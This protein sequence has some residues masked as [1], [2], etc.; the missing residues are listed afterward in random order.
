MSKLSKAVLLMLVGV[1]IVV[2]VGWVNARGAVSN[3][4][5]CGAY[6]GPDGSIIPACLTNVTSGCT[7]DWEC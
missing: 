4:Y 5:R 3:E 1:N 6:I 7:A 2:G